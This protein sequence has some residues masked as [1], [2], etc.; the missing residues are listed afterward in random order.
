MQS[1]SDLNTFSE[2]QIE[3]GDE[4]PFSVVFD[5]TTPAD[6]DIAV[7]ENQPAVLT[8]GIEILE[9]IDPENCAVV[10]EIDMTTV[11]VDV[12]LDFGTVPANVTITESPSNFWTISGINSVLDWN[13]VKS[14]EVSFAFGTVGTTTF[15]T[16]IEHTLPDSTRGTKDTDYTA[17]ITAVNSM[18]APSNEEYDPFELEFSPS[19]PQITVDTG[20]FNPTFTMTISPDDLAPIDA[21]RVTQPDSSV[22]DS[23]TDT[24]VI[25][26]EKDEINSALNTLEIDFTGVNDNFVMNYT[27]T[28]NLNS[29]VDVVVQEYS[30]DVFVAQISSAFSFGPEDVEIERAFFAEANIATNTTTSATGVKVSLQ[31]QWT[32][33]V[34]SNYYGTTVGFDGDYVIAGEPDHL[35]QSVT[36]NGRIHIYN[37]SNGSLVSTIENPNTATSTSFPLFGA[38]TV[39]DSGVGIALSNNSSGHDMFAYDLST[40]G[41]NWSIDSDSRTVAIGGG[42]VVTKGVHNPGSGVVTRLRLYNASNGSLLDTYDFTVFSGTNPGLDAEKHVDIYGDNLIVGMPSN[43]TTGSS[44]SF[45]GQV[46][47]FDLSGDDFD[48][49][50]TIDNPSPAAENALGDQFGHA[51]SISDTRFLVGVPNEDPTGQGPTYNNG[52]TYVYTLSTGSLEET[53]DNFNAAT[54]DATTNGDSFGWWVDSAADDSVIVARLEDEAGDDTSDRGAVY[55]YDHVHRLYHALTGLGP[56]GGLKHSAEIYDDYF[57]IGQLGTIYMYRYVEE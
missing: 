42:R 14:P 55:Y 11:P 54:T 48:L 28:N 2:T 46:F 53:L 21:M 16:T 40:G 32:K 39:A 37:A 23:T 8:T 10:Y 29:D 25:N 27:L 36:D 51:V 26:G 19:V 12:D 43:Q 41:L 1:M 35:N 18:S 38:Y 30:S 52:K 7:F 17:V 45:E 22:F 57:V 4:R 6:Q 31:Q 33:T 50:Y 20:V 24:L 34:S 56:D 49:T 5:V 13:S 47:V 15:S 44:S 3:F 9:I